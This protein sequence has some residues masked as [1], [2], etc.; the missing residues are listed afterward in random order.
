MA[1]DL[2]FWRQLRRLYPHVDAAAWFRDDPATARETAFRNGTLRAAY[3]IVALRALGLDVGAVSGFDADQ[4][5]R[6]FFASTTLEANFICNIGYGD[7]SELKPRLPRLGYG[8]I[9]H[10]STTATGH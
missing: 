2:E 6:G 10:P 3:L 5:N 1:H 9:L 7:H 4:V 8:E